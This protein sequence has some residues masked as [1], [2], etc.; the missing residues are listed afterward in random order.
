MKNY[1]FLFIGDIQSQS[2]ID[3]LKA[4]IG[5]LKEKYKPDFII[6]N[7]EN[8]SSGRSCTKSE[9]DELFNLGI[10]VLTGG[11]H[12]FDKPK[13]QTLLKEHPYVLRPYNFPSGTIG[14]GFA[15]LKLDDKKNIAVVNLQGRVFMDAIDCPFRSMEALLSNELKDIKIIFV[16]FHAETTAEKYAFYKYFDGKIS[17]IVGTHTHI[18]T[19]DDQLSDLGTAFIS[20]VGMTGPYDSVIGIKKDAPINRFLYQ[21][22]Q[23]FVPAEENFQ[24]CGVIIEIN[25]NGKAIAIE[26]IFYPGLKKGV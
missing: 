14:K 3:F 1:K 16:D 26:K 23:Y 7:A 11:N 24:I 2:S 22:P 20:D 18:Q 19:N 12:S 21:T 13:G 8:A 17:A 9:A 5:Y 6:A 4:N 15:I 10:N 25:E